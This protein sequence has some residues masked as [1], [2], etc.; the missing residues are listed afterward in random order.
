MTIIAFLIF[1]LEFYAD[2]QHIIHLLFRGE[3]RG[4]GPWYIFAVVG[5]AFAIF[6]VT[7]AALSTK[8]GSHVEI[9]GLF[10]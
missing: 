1:L 6:T 5:I 9:F 2:L 8:K 4:E 10:F 7:L 3:Y